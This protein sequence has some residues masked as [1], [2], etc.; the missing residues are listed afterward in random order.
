MK[1]IIHDSDCSLHNEPAFVKWFNDNEEQETRK[2]LE[3]M[4]KAFIAGKEAALDREF[5]CSKCMLRVSN[6]TE[7][8]SP[9]F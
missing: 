5:I 8:E 7:E 9:N 4:E 2:N 3:L 6:G 1:R